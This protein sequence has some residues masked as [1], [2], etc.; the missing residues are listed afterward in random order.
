MQYADYNCYDYHDSITC[1]E[2]ITQAL[3]LRHFVK[4]LKIVDFIVRPIKIFCDN[5]TT[6]FFC[7][8]NES[9]SRNKGIDIKYLN[10]RENI[11]RHEVSIEHLSTELM[12]VDPMTKSLPVKQFKSH[13]EHMRLINSFLYLVSL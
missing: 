3:W 11:K 4:G 5:S 12:I 7:K 6:Y 1:Y 8:N 10:M 9:R 13:V 2:F